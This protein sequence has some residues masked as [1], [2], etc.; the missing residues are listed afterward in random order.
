MQSRN[1]GYLTLTLCAGFYILSTMALNYSIPKQGPFSYSS[2]ILPLSV[3]MLHN[4]SQLFQDRRY[5]FFLRL[6]VGTNS[7]IPTVDINRSAVVTGTACNYDELNWPQKL[8]DFVVKYVGLQWNLLNWW[9][10]ALDRLAE[11][12]LRYNIKTFNIM[13]CTQGRANQYRP[14]NCTRPANKCPICRFV[15]ITGPRHT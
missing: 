12:Q 3:T 8:C 14:T 1:R 15:I 10:V 6:F 13:A 5:I 2:I 9:T 7:H 11:R 4:Y